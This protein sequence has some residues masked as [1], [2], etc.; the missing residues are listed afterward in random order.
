MITRIEAEQAVRDVWSRVNDNYKRKVEQEFSVALAFFEQLQ[1][2]VEEN[3]C[4]DLELPPWLV[5]NSE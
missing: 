5:S 4:G 2:F 1:D 3:D